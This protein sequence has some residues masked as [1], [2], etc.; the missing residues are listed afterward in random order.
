LS[1]RSRGVQNMDRGRGRELFG[2]AV[3]RLLTA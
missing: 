2:R 1:G 3:S